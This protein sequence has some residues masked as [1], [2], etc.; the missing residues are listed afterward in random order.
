MALSDRAWRAIDES[1]NP[2]QGVCLNL[3]VWKE[4]R[5]HSVVDMVEAWK[6]HAPIKPVRSKV[7]H[8]PSPAAALV[9]AL[10]GALEDIVQ[11]GPE[12]VFQRH[13]WAAKAVRTGVR[14]LGLAVLADEAVAA[15]TVTTVLLPDTVNELALRRCMLEKYGVAL[16]GGPSEIGIH[17]VR[18][19]SMGLG[20]H[21]HVQLPAF[22]ALGR[23]LLYL[24][25]ACIENAGV[26]AAEN[27]FSQAGTG[28]WE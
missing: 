27:V 28:F 23:C 5:Q 20:A 21:P 18:I 7:I 9:Y 26:L 11:E 8:G 15:R 24:G 17:A 3:S 1:P 6:T 25:H 22:E 16:G 2:Y 13:W 14:A 19:G 12:K 4:Y 10:L